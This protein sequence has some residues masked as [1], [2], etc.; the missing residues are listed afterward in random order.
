[1]PGARTPFFQVR[2]EGEDVTSWVSSVSLTEDDKQA[3]SVSVT[4]PDPRMI[5]S[6][7][8]FE[9]CVAEV[10][11]GYAEP[12]QHALMLRATITKVEQ[13]YPE[14]GV[15]TLTLK[16]EDKS[17]LMGLQEKKKV[18]RNRTVT[19]IVRAI[20]QPYG[21][22][23]V[24]ARLDPDP[25]VSARPITQDG[26]TDL[27]FLQELAE[28]YHAKCFVE[29]DE[30]GREVLYFLPERRIVTLR[31]PERL[32]LRYRLGADSNLN[33]FAPAFDS[34]YI[35][36]LK[37]VSDVDA[38]GETVNSQERPPAEI[39]IWSLSPGRLAQASS[40]D[41]T[42]IERLYEVGA[43][44]KRDLQAQLAS[45]RPAVGRVV[46]DRTE[47]ESTNDSLEARR[48]G[49]TATGSTFGNIWLRAKSNVVID[50]ANE[51]FNGEWYTSSVTHKADGGKYTTDF[52]CV[53]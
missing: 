22:S 19:D 14:N 1:L 25:S 8:L 5:Y 30:Q 20:A 35:D 17:I 53:R 50:G 29:L 9:G 47:L 39:V 23:R 46:A 6:D 2:I 45:R 12:D 42:R 16:G 37:E 24:E 18:W 7:A 32:V 31:R 26:K 21:F 51:R 15:P 52:K 13:T 27:A 49:M 38:N 3:D 34:S 41:R 11:M 4:I 48:Q 10:D 36:R 33:S 28:T 40:T 43:A 44:R